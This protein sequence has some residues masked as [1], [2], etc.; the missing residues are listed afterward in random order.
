MYLQQGLQRASLTA[1]GRASAPSF[2]PPDEFR[3]KTAEVVAAR[4]TIKSQKTA[5]STEAPTSQPEKRGGPSSATNN[6]FGV[7]KDCAIDLKAL[8]DKKKEE[9]SNGGGENEA[10]ENDAESQAAEGAEGAQEKAKA[11]GEGRGAPL[12][13]VFFSGK[14]LRGDTQAN[15][16]SGV[17][18]LFLCVT[19]EENDCSF[20]GLLLHFQLEAGRSSAAEGAARKMTERRMSG[21]RGGS[22]ADFDD[23][24]NAGGRGRTPPRS[25]LPA[26]IFPH[27]Y[28]EGLN[29]NK[30][31]DLGVGT[32]GS[33]W[34]CC[35]QVVVRCSCPSLCSPNGTHNH[36]E[37]NAGGE[38]GGED[39]EAQSS[40]LMAVATPSL[41]WQ[42]A[43]MSSSRAIRPRGP[44]CSTSHH[45]RVFL[46]AAMPLFFALAMGT[47]FRQH[48]MIRLSFEDQGNSLDKLWTK[49][50]RG[51]SS[52]G[53]ETPLISQE[54]RVK[55]EGVFDS[56]TRETPSISPLVVL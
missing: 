30:S 19:S 7:V 17:F 28:G 27:V 34:G 52:R 48:N 12:V 33:R 39:V 24:L 18:P 45:C 47:A 5:T 55:L 51:F 2:A 15:D 37:Q 14:G 4:P 22:Q 23:I 42:E 56:R 32:A 21:G 49:F 20:V 40:F 44:M 35:G 26:F 46:S 25:S 53:R 6:F 16:Q 50:Q 8:L 36:F 29:S 31:P 9:R 1:R 11:Q 54:S 43:G 10:A 13:Y 38:R 3:G 41:C